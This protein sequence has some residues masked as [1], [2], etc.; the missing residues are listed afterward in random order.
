MEIAPEF[1]EKEGM[2]WSLLI[3]VS[4]PRELT[5]DS[6]MMNTLESVRLTL[7]KT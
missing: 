4:Q 1:K 3:Q 6:E 2:L 5:G 7:S